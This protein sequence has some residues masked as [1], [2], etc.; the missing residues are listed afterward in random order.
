[1]ATRY[2]IRFDDITP[3]MA[4]S[5]FLP[6]KEMLEK[7]GI[8][9]L[10]GVVPESR[11]HKLEVEDVRKDFFEL[12]RSW[13]LYGDSIAQH[14]MYH[15]YDSNSAGIL[16]I[17]PRSEFA[18][19]SYED[20]LNR[21]RK[22]KDIL[23]DEGVWQPWFMAPAHSFDILT[24]DALFQLKFTA[25]TDGYGFYPY[26]IKSM[27]LVPQMTSFPLKVGFGVSTIC[28]HINSMKENDIRNLQNFIMVNK[29]KFI[30]FKDVVTAGS[31]DNIFTRSTRFMSELM[32]KIYRVLR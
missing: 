8:K 23:I 22:G 4:W 1:M 29:E 26:Y 18:G 21:I 19:H 3:G 27:L 28:V 2:I 16:T 7:N 25:I 15:C 9:S 6:F 13:A 20:Q 10:L 32:L 11:D 12:V 31:A 30:D 17:N 5:K 14:G 24:I